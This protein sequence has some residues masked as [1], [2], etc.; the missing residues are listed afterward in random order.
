MANLLAKLIP[1][2][3]AEPQRLGHRWIAAEVGTRRSV[4]RVT[5]NADGSGELDL[6]A[7]EPNGARQHLATYAF[8]PEAERL[9]GEPVGPIVLRDS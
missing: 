4:A 2:R 9:A 7:V 1:E 3:G 5:M 6:F 8:G